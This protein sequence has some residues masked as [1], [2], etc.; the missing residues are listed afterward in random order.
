ML[1]NS[2]TAWGGPAKLLHAAGAALV[3]VLLAHGAW[4]VHFAPRSGR[5]SLYALHGEIGY[6]LL[7]IV[8]VRVVWRAVNPTP[9]L[10]ETLPPRIRA[11][12]RAGHA[13]L[14]VTLV[15]ASLT[16][17]ILAGTF[18]QPLSATLFGSLPVPML[19]APG[20]RALHDATEGAHLVS[21]YALLALAAGHVAMA[22]IHARTRD[23]SFVRRM[24]W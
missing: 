15:V 17:W 22:M 18:S 11:L 20:D 13:L 8:L 1:R 9:A 10:P 19:A 24:G 6:Y 23:A 14:Y 12:A 3:A 21:S 7:L 16:G 2:T 4:M 5:L